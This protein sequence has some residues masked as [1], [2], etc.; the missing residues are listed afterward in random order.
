MKPLKTT[1]KALLIFLATL[2]ST[3][4]FAAQET[5]DK[6]K[7][8]LGFFD[9]HYCNWPDR[10]PFLM[11]VYATHRHDDIESIEVYDPARNSLGK[12]NLNKFRYIPATVVKNKSI[13]DKKVFINQI[14]IPRNTIK[15]E[16][17]A[18]VVTNNKQ[19]HHYADWMFLDKKVGSAKIDFPTNKASNISKTPILKWQAPENGQYYQV[20]IKDNWTGKS[21]YS[22]KTL[23]KT[24]FKV[25]DKLLK[26]DGW[27]AWKVHAKDMDETILYGDFNAGSLS[28]YH[29]F[30]TLP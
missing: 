13:E 24:E 2:V 18:T 14:P 19:I 8:S 4:S 30:T 6:H 28:E 22:S 20:F 5:T 16:F 10:K 17:T 9:I 27:Y 29:S 3:S 26:N 11:L 1:Y 7:D 25:P 15:G 12:M 21:I 23:N